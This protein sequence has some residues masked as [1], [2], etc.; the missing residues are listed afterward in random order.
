MSLGSSIAQSNAELRSGMSRME[1][2]VCT[3]L[4][5]GEYLATVSIGGGVV[6]MP[7]AGPAPTVGD[8]V[9]VAFLGNQPLCVGPIPRPSTGTVRSDPVD[10]K[11]DVVADN[12]TLYGGL[13][14]D[15]T[16]TPAPDHRVALDWSIQNGYIQGR[17]SSDPLLLVPPP[18]PVTPPVAPSGGPKDATFNPTES[19]TWNGSRWWL[20]EVW[21]S[22]STIGAYFYGEQVSSTIPDD[23]TIDEIRVYVDAFYTSGRAP[24]LGL[25]DIGNKTGVPSN[26][27]GTMEIAGGSGWKVLPTGWGDQMKL[28]ARLGF[29]T[30]H[31]GYHKWSPAGVN[32]SGALYVKWHT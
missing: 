15:N 6:D 2:G 13:S 1:V 22:D 14:Y 31:G 30:Q 11:V 16:Y 5:W 3:D 10:G 24:T 12:G 18:P 32:N 17:L 8:K 25:H 29:A 19:G 27:I 4:N 7:M 23:A 20:D 28:G 26:V 9:W 21:C